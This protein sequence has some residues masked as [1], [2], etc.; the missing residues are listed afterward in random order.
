MFTDDVE[1]IETLLAH[2]V[3]EGIANVIIPVFVFIFMF[4]VDWKLALLSML[5]LPLGLLSVKAMYRAGNSR[6][7]SYYQAA[8]RMNNT[9]I[10][11]INGME[12]VK[13]F[14]KDGDSY[15]RFQKDVIDYRNLTL[16]WFGAC[17]GWTALYSTIILV[18][19][20]LPCR[21]ELF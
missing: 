10:E 2:S 13:V 1:S 19:H 21:L 6:M 9:I 3:P 12:V 5:S 14:N 16:E 20:S 15:H 8:Q 4:F 7:A 18:L 11:Y 17:R